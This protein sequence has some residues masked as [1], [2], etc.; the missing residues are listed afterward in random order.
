MILRSSEDTNNAAYE[1]QMRFSNYNSL[2]IR[3][4]PGQLKIPEINFG[5]ITL[6]GFKHAV[7]CG[8]RLIPYQQKDNFIQYPK[9]LNLS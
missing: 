7:S 8:F 5:M 6:T 3:Q 4:F 1:W 2:H 9:K